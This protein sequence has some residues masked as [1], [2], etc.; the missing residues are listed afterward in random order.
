MKVFD[1]FSKRQ[2]ELRGEVPDVYVYDAIPQPLRVQVIHIWRDALGNE[3]QYHERYADRH[4]EAQGAYQFI[5]ETLCREYGLFILPPAKPYLGRDYLEEL[6]NFL[7]NEPG[8]ERV[9]D[10]IEL[11][12]RYIDKVTR[13]ESGYAPARANDAI[14]ELNVRF[15]EQGVG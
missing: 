9:L 13:K 15:R 8:S 5:V 1:L 11:S 2:K 12:F 7:L 3:Q 4:A 10:A 14:A 6:A